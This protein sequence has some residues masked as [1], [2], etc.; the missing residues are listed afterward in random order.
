MPQLERTQNLQ[1][2]KSAHSPAAITHQTLVL[3]ITQPLIH[4]VTH[5]TTHTCIL[6]FTL[7]LILCVLSLT[8]PLIY[9]GYCHSPN[10]SYIMYIV[11][12]PTTHILC[13]LS[14]T[15]PLIHVYCHSPNHSYIYYVY[16]HSPTT[17]ILSMP[18]VLHVSIS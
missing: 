3:S 14:F 4:V 9:Y 15:Q 10:H 12:H 18:I 5:P 6:S 11:N 13:I 16:C 8:Q 17:Q 2:H 7:P 1:L